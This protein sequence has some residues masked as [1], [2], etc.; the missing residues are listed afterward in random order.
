[1]QWKK[2]FWPVVGS[3]AVVF[4][5]SLLWN[6]LRGISLTDVYDS[7]AAIPAHRLLLSALGALV[8]YAA[9]AGYD[10][11]ALAHI[12]KKVSLLFV[13]LCSFTTYALSHNIGGSVLSGAV[14]RYRAYA[15]KGL[16]GPEIGILVA[17]CW[18]T[19]VIAMVLVASVLLV[20]S[21][22]LTERFVGVLPGSVSA[23]TGVVGLLL[24]ALYVFGSWLHLKPL[25][26]GGMQ[27][28]YPRLPIV[29]AQLTVGPIEILA[30]ASIVYFALPEAGNPGYIVVLGI[31][32]DRL[33]HRLDLARAGRA[34][35]VRICGAGRPLRHGQGRRAG[36]ARRVPPVLPDHPA[37][38]RDDRGDRLRARPVQPDG[39][40]PGACAGTAAGGVRRA[41][42]CFCEV[43]RPLPRVAD[44]APGNSLGNRPDL[45][46]WMLSARRQAVLAGSSAPQHRCGTI[47][48]A[49]WG[50]G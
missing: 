33:L 26:I 8:A 28:F 6:E 14:I 37:D 41:S 39:A 12:G 16:S 22:E 21:P 4:S 20:F 46:I 47:G 9:I 29:F 18:F 10:S 49:C 45:T 11:I 13:S 38:H 31:F 32:V 15:T 30:A 23:A 25:K 42:D 17:V 40:D 27:L 43:H 44:A 19:F 7:L 50:I 1:M 34:R 35:R 48:A 36:G 3:V 5:L 24:I 2:Y